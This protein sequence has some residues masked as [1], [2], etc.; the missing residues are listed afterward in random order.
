MSNKYNNILKKL[1]FTSIGHHKNYD[2]MF[3]DESYFNGFEGKITK[4]R[5]NEK[6]KPE[7]IGCYEFEMWRN[8]ISEQLGLNL[9]DYLYRF[10]DYSDFYHIT[11]IIDDKKIDLKKYDK[12][13]FVNTLM[14]K[15]EYRGMDVTSEFV[16]YM[17]RNYFDRQTLMLFLI[18]PVQNNLDFND[19]YNNSTIKLEDGSVIKKSKLFELNKFIDLD[20][21]ISEFKLFNLAKKSGLERINGSNIFMLNPTKVLTRMANKHEYFKNREYIDD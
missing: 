3:K 14:L 5:V 12:I 21:E 7:V 1:T 6:L 15:S 18:K 19:I 2:F 11:D 13:V 20:F 16:E 17:Y 8:D 9:N 10:K 4:L